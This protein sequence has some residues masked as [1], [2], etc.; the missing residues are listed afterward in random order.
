MID[1]AEFTSVIISA[2]KRLNEAPDFKLIKEMIV[3]LFEITHEMPK[4]QAVF[5]R[6]SVIDSLYST[7][8][9]KMIG[10]MKELS[11]AL[12]TLDKQDFLDYY[13]N[14]QGKLKEILLARYGYNYKK[15]DKNEKGN[16]AISLISKYG[17]FLT[18]FEFPIYDSLMRQLV[19]ALKRYVVEIKP[20]DTGENLYNYF[21]NISSITKAFK[22]SVDQLDAFGWLIGK[23][24]NAQKSEKKEIGY[25]GDIDAWEEFYE[26]FA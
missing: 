10:G 25:I 15:G 23:L 9:N 3:K 13:N 24:E 4:E 8:M 11:K 12:L 17:Y 26:I 14:G 21:S 7:N 16:Q 18:N 22:V 2:H 19:N 6:L 5:L 20:Y 1:K